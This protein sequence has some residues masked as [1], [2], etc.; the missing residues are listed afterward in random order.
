MVRE[1]IEGCFTRKIPISEDCSME[2]TLSDPMQVRQ[3]QIDGLPKDEV[4]TNN[5]IMVTRGKRWPLMI[6]P[7]VRGLA[8]AAAA[9]RCTRVSV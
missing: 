3:W 1:W 9:A 4:S 2:F 6:D 8:A 7:Q 5:A